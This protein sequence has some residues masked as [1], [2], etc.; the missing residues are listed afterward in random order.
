[1]RSS[2]LPVSC[3]LDGYEIQIRRREQELQS[4]RA[5][6]WTLKGLVTLDEVIA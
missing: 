5:Y 4:L 6:V 3:S 1:M 2:S